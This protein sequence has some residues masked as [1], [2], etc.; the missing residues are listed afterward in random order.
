MT[1]KKMGVGEEPFKENRNFTL[2]IFHS[3]V[4]STSMQIQ[5]L[6]ISSKLLNLLC[7]IPFSAEMS[8]CAISLSPPS[9]FNSGDRQ[10]RRVPESRLFPAR[11]SI[12]S[13]R[14]NNCRKW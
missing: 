1:C 4:G 9:G 5:A 6:I 12:F 10:E 2:E 13:L 11:H 7:K 14:Y 3:L 8:P